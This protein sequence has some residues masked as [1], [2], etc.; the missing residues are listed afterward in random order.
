MS[1]DSGRPARLKQYEV[2]VYGLAMSLSDGNI[3]RVV[4]GVPS[5]ATVVDAGYDWE[6]QVYY[7]TLE[8]PTFPSV[9][10]GA[11]IPA[12]EVTIEDCAPDAVQDVFGGPGG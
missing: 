5:D 12:G 8:H 9:E 7:L 11:P 3:M 1:D 10:E 2:S 4:D 6:R